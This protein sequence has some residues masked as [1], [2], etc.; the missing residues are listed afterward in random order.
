MFLIQPPL[1]ISHFPWSFSFS[2]SHLLKW[3]PY[4]DRFCMIES[5]VFFLFCNKAKLY[6]FDKDGNQ[7][8][9]KGASFVK[10]LKHKESGKVHLIMRQSKTLKI[11]ANHLCMLL[12]FF[13]T[14][15]YCI[16]LL[17]FFKF[18]FIFVVVE[19][20]SVWKFLQWYRRWRCKNTPATRNHV[21]GTLLILPMVNWR[22]SSS[23]LDLLPLRVS[24][25]LIWNWF[26]LCF[27]NVLLVFLNL[28]I[29]S[30]I[31][32]KLSNATFINFGH[33][34]SFNLDYIS[35]RWI[36]AWFI[37]SVGI[38]LKISKK[39]GIMNLIAQILT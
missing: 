33:C 39:L 27:V 30:R 6:R 3:V 17:L 34:G 8:K 22:T 10:F 15:W 25:L 36:F 11:C 37:I 14:F 29:K 24:V 9:E 28:I 7:C 2:F 26:P 20:W 4:M 12:S 18:S 13:L 1:P 16:L 35:A 21:C 32:D 5:R 38:I 31:Q 19:I 23:A